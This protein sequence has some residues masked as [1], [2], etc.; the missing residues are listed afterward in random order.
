MEKDA[1]ENA[2][3]KEYAGHGFKYGGSSA[4]INMMKKM[5]RQLEKNEDKQAQ[6]AEELA[7]LLED[8]ELPV[9]LLAGGVLDGPAVTFQS[10]AFGYPGS[11]EL[12]KGAEFHVDGKSRIVF[13]G[14][15]GNGKTTLVKL[16]LGEL[17]PTSGS[18]KINRGA[19]ISLVNQHHADQLDLSMTPLEFML[20]KFPGEGSTAHELA[21]R[22]HLSS[23]GVETTQQTVRASSLS[24]GQRSRVAMAAVSYERPHILVMDEPTNNLDLASIEA[25]AASVKAF[26]GGVV[27]VSHDQFFV[28]QVA[29]EVWNV[30]N[31]TVKR[32]ESFESYRNKI[33][34]RI[35]KK[36]L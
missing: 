25:L 35:Q 10:V 11:K 6:E 32:L 23:C 2:K 36:G 12:F 13:V 8:G 5:E 17:S 9:K 34:S 19:R 4:Q 28:S 30:G 26:D 21:L 7:D 24:G 33:L 20:H 31:G 18:V 27:L 16:L 3:L 22:S 15:N 1:A 29:K 14:E